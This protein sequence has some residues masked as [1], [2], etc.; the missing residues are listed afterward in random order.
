AK[1]EAIHASA[2]GEMDCFVAN[3][4]LRKSSAF[5]AGNDVVSVSSLL[6]RRHSGAMRSIEPGISRFRVRFA[7]RNDGVW[8]RR[9]SLPSL[10]AQ[11]SNPFHRLRSCG[12]LRYARN[13]EPTRTGGKTMS[14]GKRIVLASRPVGEPKPSDFRLE[15]C[16]VPTPGAGEV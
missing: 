4:P 12:L 15:E 9:H 11:R 14:Q 16:P 8:W 6:K 5:V 10:R 13:D 7:P 2:S 1:A 3:A